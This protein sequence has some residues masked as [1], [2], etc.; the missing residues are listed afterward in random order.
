[1]KITLKEPDLALEVYKVDTPTG[2]GWCVIMP[3][4]RKILVKLNHGQWTTDD[5]ICD[6]FVQAIGEEINRYM[7]A[8]QP[9]K[10]CNGPA[11]LT[12]RP[13]R[14]RILKYLLV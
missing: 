6:Q 2:T 14:A 13:K 9:H 11:I 1:M 5:V 12:T 7:D 10:L 3:D 8:N 4:N